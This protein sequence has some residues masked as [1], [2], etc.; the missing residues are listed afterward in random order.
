[1]SWEHFDD[2]CP[3][4]KPAIIDAI[5]RKV[6]P[7]DHPIVVAAMAGFAET[8]L[9]E[10]QGWHRFTCQNSRAPEDIAAARAV[11]FRMEQKM[12]SSTT[13]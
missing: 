6:L 7:D 2:N 8:T 5:T 1:M 3:G 13:T 9:A 11:T 10:R 4:C 12:K